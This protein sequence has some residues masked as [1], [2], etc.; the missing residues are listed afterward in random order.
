MD[1]ARPFL[2]SPPGQVYLGLDLGGTKLLALAYTE[3]GP[4][5]WHFSTGP[6][7]T[8]A[9]LV[10]YFTGVMAELEPLGSVTAGLAVPGIV[11]AEGTVAESDVLPS[12]AGWSPREAIPG[13]RLNAVLNDGDAALVEVAAGLAPTATVAAIGA[14]TGTAAALQI[15][16]VRLRQLR[17][18]AGELGYVPFGRE[19]ILDDHAPGAAILRRLALSPTAVQA[20]L[21]AGDVA[22]TEAIR[23]AGEAF[24][25]GL[26]TL[27]N[28]IHP[29]RIGLYGGTLRYDGYLAAALAAVEQAAHPL[30]RP[31]CEI[32]VVPEAEEI[33]ARG[34][35]RQAL[36][37]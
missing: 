30:L 19:G 8:P 15:G 16:G 27:I 9:E 35:L 11:T 1:S 7:C 3:A 29:E 26:A 37:V 10:S 13:W 6:G 34:A 14:G 12:L 24:G 23:R 22:V 25:L 31:G 4:R 33:V 28:L 32:L 5:R 21:A 20:G 2:T 17:P 36:T 18:Y